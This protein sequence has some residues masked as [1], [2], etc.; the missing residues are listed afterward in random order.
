MRTHLAPLLALAGLLALPA[1]GGARTVSNLQ[2]VHR[3]GQTFVTWTNRPSTGWQ[4]LVYASDA[5]LTNQ[6]ALDTA[7]LVGQVGDSSAV[8]RRITQLLGGAR[9]TFRLDSLATPLPLSS[10]LFV[11]TPS[12]QRSRWYAVIADS[13]GGQ[14]T[15]LL[16][17]Q[18][19]S[20]QSVFE[21]PARPE[22]V[23]QRLLTTPVTGHDYV[24]WGTP[25]AS[26]TTRPTSQVEG[27]AHHFGLIRG[28]QHHPLMLGGHGRGGSFFNSLAGTGFIGENIIAIDD[29]MP[30]SDYATF[31]L[32]LQQG[33]SPSVYQ[34]A[35]ATLGTPVEPSTENRVLQLLDWAEA[36]LN[37]DRARV[38]VAGGSMGGT[39][40]VLMAYRHA[41]RIAAAYG[42]IPKLCFAYTPDSYPELRTSME[43][44]W[45]SLSPMTQLT[46]GEPVFDYMDA[47]ALAQAAGP[48]GPAPHY[49]F[50]GRRDSITGW[51]EKYAYYQVM[52]QARV[53]GQIFWDTRDHY[54]PNNEAPWRPTQTSKALYRFRL[55][56]SYPALSQCSA[57][58]WMGDGSATVGDTMGTI[59]GA[60]EWD[61]AMVDVEG[62][63][64]CRLYTRV[65]AHKY[66]SFPA[67]ESLT[68]DVTPRRLQRFVVQAGVEY[69]WRV[70]REPENALV[71]E[72]LVTPDARGLLTIPAVK[73]YRTGTRLL[74]EPSSVVAV[75]PGGAGRGPRLQWSQQP[76]RGRVDLA[77]EW[78]DEG[79]AR[80]ELLDLA[81]RRVRVLHTGAARDGRT[82][83]VETRG[84]R[85]GVYLVH[86]LQ[87]AHRASERLVVL[88]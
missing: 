86:A 79:P 47:R 49:F 84:L 29:W 35:P 5:P 42:L 66:G 8:D 4:Y 41:S 30:T 10:G 38:Y 24:Y 2:V 3:T 74:L 67:P 51:A 59:N 6:A 62:G 72:G 48:A 64:Q 36:K 83:A 22:P 43:R 15:T 44:M 63:W 55:D 58:Q 20:A 82:V 88:R 78:W 81:G 18:N 11:H 26:A 53:G 46:T 85:P 45:G 77:M 28:F 21:V 87:G 25:V 54:V 1:P 60:V 9:L 52:Q 69:R 65:L 34:N 13:A 56:R 17:G 14:L 70:L 73:V 19:T 68:V 57:D 76:A 23:W 61:S 12:V 33:Y 40:A 71:A 39:F 7:E 16:P 32:G 80:L 75:T 37:H 50:I 31:Y 27:T